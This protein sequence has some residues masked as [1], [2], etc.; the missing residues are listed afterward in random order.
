MFEEM[1]LQ[2]SQEEE[3]DYL[4][5]ISLEE[6]DE[7]PGKNDVVADELPILALKNTVLFPNNVIPITVGRDKSIKAINKAY[8]NNRQ[9]AVISQR[10]LKLEDPT[11]QD[12]FRVGTVA[13]ILKLLKTP[14]GTLTA[15]LQGRHRFE[16]LEMITEEPYMRGRVK[17]LEYTQ[18]AHP[19][20]FQAMV[21]SIKELAENIID[22]S[23]NIPSEAVVVLQNIKSP[24]FLLNFIASNMGANL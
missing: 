23:P 20:K 7:E 22:L 19:L 1:L 14:D 13:H 24:S 10:D 5:F 21:S 15:I 18:P 8:E 9:I 12:L 2:R 4:P 11:E 16:L 17:V 3:A 6:E